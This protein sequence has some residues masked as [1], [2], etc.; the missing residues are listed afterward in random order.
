MEEIIK[1]LAGYGVIV[2]EDVEDEVKKEGVDENVESDCRMDGDLTTE[3]LISE[4]VKTIT[5]AISINVYEN[6][7]E[8]FSILM[9]NGEKKDVMLWPADTLQD[10]A[11]KLDAH[12]GPDCLLIGLQG[13]KGVSLPS[14]KDMIGMYNQKDWRRQIAIT[15]VNN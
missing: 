7:R 5:P 3:E 1:K 11:A 14:S 6:N 10:L 12:F 4:I 13:K 2:I 9:P 8:S 15:Y